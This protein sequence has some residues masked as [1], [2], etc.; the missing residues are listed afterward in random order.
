MCALATLLLWEAVDRGDLS[1]VRRLVGRVPDLDARHSM[2]DY[3]ALSIAAARGY[4]NILLLLLR[5]G[6]NPL[7]KAPVNGWTALHCAVARGRVDATAALLEAGSDPLLADKDGQVPLDLCD[8]DSVVAALLQ[9]ACMAAQA[10]NT[11]FS[12]PTKDV[13]DEESPRYTPVTNHSVDTPATS[14]LAR[15]DSSQSLAGAASGVGVG[16]GVGGSPNVAKTARM[17]KVATTPNTRCFP[18]ILSMVARV[19]RVGGRR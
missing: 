4:T 12:R 2:S 10:S 18:P 19:L 6:A 8:A 3:T 7:A 1:A 14:C 9:Q 16:V 13:G 17:V 5:A 11:C 15:T